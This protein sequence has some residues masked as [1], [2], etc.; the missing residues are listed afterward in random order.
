MSNL[1]EAGHLVLLFGGAF[2]LL[3]IVANMDRYHNLR[4][5][6]LVAIFTLLVIVFFL[7]YGFT[8]G[9]PIRC[10]AGDHF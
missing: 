3:K 5:F 2:L 1:F 7:E 9:N 6:V 8:L 10:G 4:L